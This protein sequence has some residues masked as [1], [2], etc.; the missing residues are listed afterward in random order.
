MPEGPYE[1]SVERHIAAPPETVWQVM[2]ERL[3]EWWCPKPWTTE[4]VEIDWRPGGRNATIMHGPNGEEF[5][6]EGVFLEIVPNRRLVFTDA[7]TAGWLPKQPFMI[8][9]FELTSE[10][11][12]TRYR[13]GA[14]H[15][16]EAALQQ[17][18]EMGF[19]MGWTAVGAQL[20]ALSEAA[21]IGEM[22]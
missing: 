6:D 20:A 3:T 13:A 7:F 14:R 22:E 4:I 2:T 1:L 9:F 21:A 10:G 11:A 12:G 8:G 5:A 18:K 15:W 17:H 16:N 19:E